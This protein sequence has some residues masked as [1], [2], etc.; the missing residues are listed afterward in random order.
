MEQYG[1]TGQS[2]FLN[3]VH[4]NTHTHQRNQPCNIENIIILFYYHLLI[5]VPISFGTCKSVENKFNDFF[6]LFNID[7]GAHA[8]AVV[9]ASAAIARHYKNE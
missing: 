9:A 7:D 5:H 2:F 4:S 6:L 1:T 8:A 3:S